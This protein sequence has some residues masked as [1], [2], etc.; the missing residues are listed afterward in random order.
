MTV[1]KNSFSFSG[2]TKATVELAAALDTTKSYRSY[3]G[4]GNDSI[5]IMLFDPQAH[6]YDT[7]GGT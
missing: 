6:F 1:Q 3:S 5:K 4:I 2:A 7:C